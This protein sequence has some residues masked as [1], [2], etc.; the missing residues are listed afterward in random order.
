VNIL[1]T[2]C[3]RGGSK[4]IPGK[5]IR[6]LQ[7]KP[8]IAYSIAH[9][10]SFAAK[11]NADIALSTDDEEIKKAAAT[12]G[13]SSEYTRPDH[14]ASDTSGKVEAIQHIVKFE[15]NRKNIRYD[16]VL[17]LDVSA[18]LRNMDDMIAA[19]ELIRSD[20]AALNL[21]SVSNAVKNPYFNMVEQQEDGYFQ[22]VKKN[23]DVF[24]RQKA[25]K[26]YEM[27]AS[28]YFYKKAFFDQGFK[29]PVT[30]RSLIYIMPHT[31]F[32]LDHV[33]DFE[34]L[35]YLM[36]NNKLDFKL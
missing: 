26:V 11:T 25:P 14:L 4:G 18:P 7:K 24:S 36:E 2:I 19:Y 3:A 33:I 32:D 12:W 31:S 8:L 20:E 9:A 1:I 28:F 29:A 6:M 10:Q 27:N 34:F 13:L 15:E 17:D 22:L 30:P 35:D 16:L 23:G 5:N 21:F